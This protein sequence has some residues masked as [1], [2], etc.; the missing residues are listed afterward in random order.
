MNLRLEAAAA[1][2]LS[3]NFKDEANYLIPKIDWEKTTKKVMTADLVTGIQINNRKAILKAGLEPRIILQ[4]ASSIFFKQVFHH[5]F[6]HGDI[7]PG[8]MFVNTSGEIISVDFGIMG[9]LDIQTRKYLAE[10]LLAFL[11]RDYSLVAKIYSRAGWIPSNQS[12]ASFGQACCAIAEPI[13][14]KPLCEISIGAFLGQLLEIAKNFEIEP[15]PQLF[16]LQKTMLTAEGI[17]RQLCPNINMWAIARSFIESPSMQIPLRELYVKQTFENIF[18]S[19]ERIANS[20]EY[21]QDQSTDIIDDKIPSN[22]NA[23]REIKKN[24]R[25]KLLISLLLGLIL[26]VLLGCYFF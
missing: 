23:L 15:Q 11:N 5:G 2:E 3:N 4:R 7:H 9:R 26:G 21:S 25:T 1:T 17:S 14:D 24:S 22:Q 18:N 16:L 6:F 12:V 8:N 19:I 10:I 20:F 13:L